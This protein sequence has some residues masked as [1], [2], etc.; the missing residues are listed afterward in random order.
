[1]QMKKYL[2]FALATVGMLSSCSSDDVVGSETTPTDNN[3]LVPI[4]VGLGQMA[5]RGTGTVGGFNDATD[6]V[7]NKQVVNVYMLYKDT[8]DL[9][10]FDPLKDKTP[11]YDNM[12]FY[13]PDI[14]QTGLAVATDDSIKYYPTQKKFDF[15]GYR[16]DDAIVSGAPVRTKDFIYIDFVMNGSQDI[17]AA[18]AYPSLADT[19]AL[20]TAEG[21]QDRAFSAYAARH[22]VQPDLKFRHLLSRLT[23]DI[24][25]GNEKAIDNATPV[26]IDSIK[27]VSPNSGRLTVACMGDLKGEKQGIAWNT[28]TAELPLME[29]PELTGGV[30]KNDSLKLVKLN[31]VSLANRG[32]YE[33]PGDAS[34][35]FV[36]DTVRIGEALLVAPE[37]TSYDVIVYL[38]QPTHQTYD[39]IT[40]DVTRPVEYSYKDVIK[41][42]GDAPFQA[43]Y[44][45]KVQIYLYGLQ[46]IQIKTTLGKWEEGET[47][48]LRPEDQD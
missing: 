10:V 18:K 44:S 12:S 26:W 40:A 9:A 23:F 11:L 19:V 4:R 43:G 42:T 24:I 38:R 31:S 36:A 2:F 20:T 39:D 25:P 16:L 27:V 6:N 22:G 5:T 30:T 7:W 29:R 33:T 14:A 47:I 34:T 17:M 21:F 3:S 45:Y 15:W 13:T 37:V 32:H 41:L 28:K 46:D 35:P 1:M 48:V 8:I